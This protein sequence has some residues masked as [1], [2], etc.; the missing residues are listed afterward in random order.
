[1]HISGSP[2]LY[3][4]P[5]L[6]C[7]GKMG[8]YLFFPKNREKISKVSKKQQNQDIS[9]TSSKKM[10]NYEQ[11]IYISLCGQCTGPHLRNNHYNSH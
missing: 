1:M 7:F 3:I 9:C 5:H 2:S 11:K 6:T 8:Q 4:L 10:S